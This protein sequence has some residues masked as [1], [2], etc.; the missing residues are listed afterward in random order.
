M[1]PSELTVRYTGAKGGR[2]VASSLAG[3]ARALRRV[4]E[5]G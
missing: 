4:P 3:A 1:V 5:L 2:A